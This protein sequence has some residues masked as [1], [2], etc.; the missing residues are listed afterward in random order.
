MNQNEKET[1]IT[2]GENNETSQDNILDDEMLADVSGGAPV[3]PTV[4]L[5][6]GPK[7]TSP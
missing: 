6:A 1:P 5:A 7:N 3:L 4:D 2:P